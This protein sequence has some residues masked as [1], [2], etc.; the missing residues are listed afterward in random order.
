M[1]NQS[2]RHVFISRVLLLLLMGLVYPVSW[3]PAVAQDPVGVPV[4]A[5]ED[6]TFSSDCYYQ[7]DTMDET[8]TI[9]LESEVLPCAPGTNLHSFV[10]T[11][12]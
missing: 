8:W 2:G 4:I 10:T 9:V 7:R 12:D 11:E 1:R 3:A 6:L 5:V